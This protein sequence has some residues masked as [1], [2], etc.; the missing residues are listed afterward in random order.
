MRR[1][2]ILDPETGFDLSLNVN[3][4]GI[5]TFYGG[6]HYAN[7]LKQG[8]RWV[9]RVGSD[10]F[11]DTRG[12]LVA[13][14]STDEFTVKLTDPGGDGL[15]AG[16]YT[17]RNPGGHELG[18][19]TTTGSQSLLAYGTTTAD[20]TFT[21]SGTGTLYLHCKGS[22]TNT[23][24][25]VILPDHV[26]SYDGGNRWNQDMLDYLGGLN[27]TVM[28]FMDTVAASQSIEQTWS[29]RMLTTDIIYHDFLW[30]S[31]S[32][33]LNCMPWEDVIDLSNRLNV[34][35]WICL[36]HR[37]ASEYWTSCATLFQSNLNSDRSVWIELGNEVWNSGNPWGDG[38]GWIKHLNFTKY[39]NTV[40]PAA[41]TIQ[42]TGH[43]FSEGDGIVCWSTYENREADIAVNYQMRLGTERT[44]KVIDADN[45]Q[46][47]ESN[48]IDIA[49][50]VT[51]QIN[52]TYADTTEAGKTADLDGDYGTQCVAI[53][54]D[55]E[56]EM[57]AARVKKLMA[58]Q[59]ATVSVTTNRFDATGVSGRA[60]YVAIAP[61]FTGEMWMVGVD[62]ATTVATPKHYVNV[63]GVTVYSGC[64]ASGSTPTNAEVI[65][66]T[67]TGYI[68]ND[69]VVSTSPNSTYD[70]H[71]QVTGLV[72]STS[73]EM[74]FI[75]VDPDGYQWRINQTFTA[76]ASV[77]SEYAYDTEAN[78]ATRNRFNIFEKYDIIA[79]HYAEA[80]N[81][82]VI[83]YESGNHYADSRTDEMQT[84]MDSYFLS[85]DY[86]ATLDYL[87]DTYAAAGMKHFCYFSDVGA[88]TN[89]KLADSYSDDTDVRYLG[90]KA[91]GGGV[92]AL[93]QITYAD[94]LAEQT[95]DPASLPH[96][97][98]TFS[99]ASLTYTIYGG[100]EAGVFDISG[101][102]L[103]VADDSNVNWSAPST[104]TLHIEASNG[105]IST[106]FDVAVS[107]GDAWYAADSTVAWDSID[108]TDNAE[109][110]PAIGTLL[111]RTDGTG[112]TIASGLWDMGGTN[113]YYGTALTPQVDLSDPWLWEHVIDPDN[114]SAGAKVL[115][116]FYG[117]TASTYVELTTTGGGDL[118]FKIYSTTG[119]TTTLTL[120]TLASFSAGTKYAFWCFYDAAGTPTL[121]FGYNQ[122]TVGT[123]AR[124]LSH[125]AINNHRLAI[126]GDNNSA[127]SD[128]KHGSFS[129]VARTGMTLTQAK[130]LVQDL[131][132]HHSI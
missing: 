82:P 17:L 92:N 8:Q 130:A 108:D 99:D 35:P 51:G 14:T 73:Y 11:T 89:F 28:R 45:F 121:H 114:H 52:L 57:G 12:S 95:T 131:Q 69:S 116:R 80:D 124:D 71:T 113:R 53:W 96:A 128:A 119:G 107:L 1:R 87:Y 21:Y 132:D 16:D 13:T 91:H 88:T 6:V 33:A 5:S 15:P 43:P 103:R 49:P 127:D 36:P 126:G 30:A 117:G 94:E 42:H 77:S 25:A 50:V 102:S 2:L 75:M 68:A 37:S 62:L 58:S 54:G 129:F 93:T 63:S 26:T 125:I 122:T 76:T 65:A 10:A 20:R 7:I 111:P 34:D 64:Y 38:R 74:I 90:M 97:F 41:D 9:Q 24:T 60:D 109:I 118:V 19:G 81:T 123:S 86:I 32:L 61:Y 101:T 83:A 48:G 67:G 56:A 44:V 47:Y 27:M 79:N 98:H 106:F 55:F 59:S 78:Q 40:T 84:W 22:L 105:T 104:T 31:D 46:I 100:N 3:L 110:N 70:S 39:T 85:S 4:Q 29:E 72:D 66:G 112:A 23:S 115:A 18:V 120:G